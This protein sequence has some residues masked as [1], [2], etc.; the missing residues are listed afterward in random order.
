MKTPLNPDDAPVLLN[1]GAG[2]STADKLPKGFRCW[3]EVRLDIDPRSNPDILSSMTRMKLV[4]DASVDGIWC[5]HSL[6]HLANHEVGLALKEWRRVLKHDGF[7]AMT[8]PD[9]AQAAQ[10]IVDGHLMNTIYE[11]PI[12]PITPLD[13]VFGHSASI[14]AGQGSM[15][16]RTGFTGERLRGELE[17]AGFLSVEVWRHGL[18]LFAIAR[19]S[20]SPSP[21][22]GDLF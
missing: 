18:N 20:A 7:A 6:E 17:A 2:S 10:L 21:Q 3:F 13:I 14:A 11:S 8:M 22:R 12:G 5:S 15:R 1:I 9:L 16:H 19:C 4:D